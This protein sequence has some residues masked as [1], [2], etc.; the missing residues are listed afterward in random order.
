MSG[1]T[2]RGRRPKVTDGEIIGVFE[3]AGEPVLTTAEVANGLD[4][5]PRATLKRLDSLRDEGILESKRVG[6]GR[7]WWL[8]SDDPAT[9]DTGDPLFGLPTFSGDGPTDVSEHVDEH[10]AAAVAGD[11]DDDA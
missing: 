2:G 3:S 9:A 11:D 5:G 10:V 1:G 7:V 4:I 8:A 6:S